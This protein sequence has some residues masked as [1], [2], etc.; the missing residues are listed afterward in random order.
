M[1][2]ITDQKI[3]AWESWK[4]YRIKKYF[5]TCN[6]LSSNKRDISASV[7]AANLSSA[8]FRIFSS[9]AAIASDSSLLYRETIM[10][11]RQEE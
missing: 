1:S 4:L 8:S 9:F 10:N 6:S 11:R 2:N 7:S 3:F 5:D